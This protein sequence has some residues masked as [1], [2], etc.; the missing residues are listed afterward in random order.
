M[1][2]TLNILLKELAKPQEIVL[3]TFTEKAAHQLKE[4]IRTLLSHVTN[5]TGQPYDVS[6][7]YVGTIHSLCN[8]IL[9][10]RRFSGTRRRNQKP[11]LL[12]DI[13]QYFYLSRSW[14]WRNLVENLGLGE[15]LIEIY[16]TIN[17]YFG[18]GTIVQGF[19]CKFKI[20]CFL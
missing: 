20:K 13:E 2:N 1:M 6:R 12:D 16:N 17:G 7:M 19:F 3:C 9:T 11:S 4:G 14:R 5:R 15:D 8:R 10:D 18:Y